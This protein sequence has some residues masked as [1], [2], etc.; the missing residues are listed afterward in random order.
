[1]AKIKIYEAQYEA[2]AAS[3]KLPKT[4]RDK[5]NLQVK[6]QQAQFLARAYAEIMAAKIAVT[7]KEIAAYMSTHPEFDTTA[8]KAKAEKILQRARAG[9]DFAKLANEFTEDPG[10]QGSDG[11]AQGGLYKNVPKGMMI[12]TFEDSALGLKPGE[13]SPGLVETQFGYH[14]I[15]LEKAL[16]VAPAAATYD[17]RHILI[18]TMYKDPQ[19]PSARPVPFSDYVRSKLS[20]EKEDRMLAEIIARNNISVPDDF[21]VPGTQPAKA[22]AVK[23][24]PVKK[25][26]PPA[27][28]VTTRK[29]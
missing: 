6:L 15:K 17:V 20:T 18:G 19:D 8:T 2:G 28:R 1:F 4:F 7:D 9:E 22:P 13:V 16:G 14:I 24:V 11:A 5:V 29:S 12:K 26:K 27:R 10:N 21:T 3:G 25:A 23:T